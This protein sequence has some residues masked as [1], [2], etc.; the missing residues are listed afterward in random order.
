MGIM[1]RV[2]I[3]SGIVLVAA[4]GGLGGMMMMSSSK[5]DKSPRPTAAEFNAAQDQQFI[6]RVMSSIS[7]GKSHAQLPPVVL[8]RLR[9]CPYCAKVKALLDFGG[10]G[11][12][13]AMTVIDVDPLNGAGLPSSKYDLVP[14]VQFV[15]PE[16]VGKETRTEA[17]GPLIVDSAE[18]A[19]L[20]AGP[21]GF[22]GQID[23]KE[24][25]DLREYLTE[26]YTRL[27]FVA[28]NSSWKASYDSYPAFV[29][30]KYHFFFARLCGATALSFLTWWKIEP[31]LRAKIGSTDN[32]TVDQLLRRESDAVADRI[33]RLGQPKPVSFHGGAK[34]SLV[35]TDLFG[36][37]ST[38]KEQSGVVEVVKQSKLGPWWARMDDLLREIEAKRKAK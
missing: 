7:S 19:K 21:L 12:A 37:L 34:P 6:N 24:V 14:Q 33:L 35:D 9:S 15:K 26:T 18:I 10:L 36:I 17:D 16:A 20:L 31:K 29:P 28:M 23:D 4:G 8:Y 1:R 11:G 27:V 3:G 5:G 30:S 25:T 38:C 2:A 22:K 13:D 32:L